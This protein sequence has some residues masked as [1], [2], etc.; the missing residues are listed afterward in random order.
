M[1]TNYYETDR[2]LGEYL[3]FHYGEPAE[4]TPPGLVFPGVAN[5]PARCVAEGCDPS[6]LPSN[7]RGLDL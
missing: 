2:G 1:T 5:F 4:V 6:R 7:A 3:L